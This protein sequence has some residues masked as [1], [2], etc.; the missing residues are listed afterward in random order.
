M[1]TTARIGI[2][3]LTLMGCV[4]CDQATKLMAREHLPPGEMISLLGD[5]LRLE[6][7]E[8]SGAFLSVGHTLPPSLRSALFI[9]G[10]VLIVSAVLVWAL[11]SRQL[12]RVGVIGAAL[13]CGGGFSNVIDRVSYGGHVVDFLNVG[14][15]SLRTGIFN[16]ADM[17]L[18]L[19]I[20][21]LLYGGRPAQPAPVER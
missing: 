16:V 17:A 3:L 5:T 13:V 10:A 6:Y 11:R 4:G 9:F 18:M 15:G 1:K 7:T 19:G 21:L 2:I 14:I 12:S 8:N 20:A